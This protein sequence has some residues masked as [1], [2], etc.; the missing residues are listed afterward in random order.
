MLNE[1]VLNSSLYY[2]S[3]TIVNYASVWSIITIVMYD[4]S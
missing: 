4:P 2:K 1:S 3:F